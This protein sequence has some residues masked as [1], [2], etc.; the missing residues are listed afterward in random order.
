M[1]NPSAQTGVVTKADAQ[2]FDGLQ[3]LLASLRVWHPAWP[4]TV[5]DCGLTLPQRAAILRHEGVEL[6]AAVDRGF[7]IP[8]VMRHY[9]TSAVYGFFSVHDRLYPVTVHLDADAV[10]L[11]KLEDLAAAAAGADPGISGVPDY[12]ELTLAYQLGELAGARD[13]L[14][15]AVPGADLDSRTFNGGVFAVDARYY[16]QRMRPFVDRLLPHHELFWGNDMA[17]MN[18]AAYAANRSRPYIDPGHIYNT[19][20]SYRRAPSLAANRITGWDQRGLPKLAGPFGSVRVLHFVGKD[21]PWAAAAP[22]SE[23]VAC[24]RVYRELA[25]QTTGS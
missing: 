17:I 10:V 7:V 24:W 16:E 3:A 12:P 19:R 8:E 21:K 15:G 1:E 11:G 22:D 6:V 2:F 5:V 13:A 20:H 9:Y 25:R 18:F 23:S 14:D 4:V